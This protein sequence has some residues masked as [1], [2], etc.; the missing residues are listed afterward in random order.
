L[1]FIRASSVASQEIYLLRIGQ[2]PQQLT[3]DGAAKAG[4]AWTPSGREIVFASPREGALRLWRQK[5]LGGIPE[6]ITSGEQPAVSPTIARHGHRLAFVSESHNFNLWQTDLRGS[7]PENSGRLIA[8]SYSQE[9]PAYSPDGSRIAFASDRTGSPEIWLS[10]PR[11]GTLVQLTVLSSSWVGSPRWSPD[12]S[13]IAFDSA[14]EGKVDIYVAGL[15]TRH[16]RRLTNH[17]GDNMVPSWSRDGKWVYFASERSGRFEIWR[18]QANTAES[19]TI[20]ATQVTRGGGFCPVES[21]DGRY[22]YFTKAR[23]EGEVDVRAPR[24]LWRKQVT[25]IPNGPEELVIPSLQY[26]GW[27]VPGTRAIYYLEPLPGSDLELR[28]LRWDEGYRRSIELAKVPNRVPTHDSVMT[29]SP[30][31]Q[32]VIY[33]QLDAGGSDIRLIDNF[34]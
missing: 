1:A 30:D 26:W 21:H 13:E 6:A 5:V 29:I 20:P 9:E 28:L 18:V 22:L 32:R 7:D 31:G 16:V 27:W 3:Q 25:G 14:T 24:G 2:Q 17:A 19:V 33:S 10:N 8:S 34:R 15:A 23:I 4:L 11:G 12:G